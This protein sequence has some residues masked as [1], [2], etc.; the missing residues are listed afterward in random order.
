[1]T[2]DPRIGVVMDAIMDAVYD[3]PVRVVTQQGKDGYPGTYAN[4]I[5]ANGRYALAE[6]ILEALDALG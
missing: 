6:K 2:E 5:D 4:L 1:M 3:S